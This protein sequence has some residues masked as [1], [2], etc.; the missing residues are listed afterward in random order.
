MARVRLRP[1]VPDDLHSI[2]QYLGDK[3]PEVANRFLSVI[4]PTFDDLSRMP[5]KGSLKQYRAR[6]L[7]GI[8]SWL[9]PTF[10]NY[11]ILY[12]PIEEGIEVIAVVHGSR[13]LVRLLKQRLP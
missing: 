10:R 5:G 3:S 11:L 9:V 12:R 8:R 13:N 6:K 4:K 7:A 2:Y 1:E